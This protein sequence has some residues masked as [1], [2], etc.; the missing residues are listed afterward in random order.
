MARI[1]YGQVPECAPP[2]MKK[3]YRI[4]YQAS[5]MDYKIKKWIP[6][7][8]LN[9][10]KKRALS[11]GSKGYVGFKESTGKWSIIRIYRVV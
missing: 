2:D 8:F 7:E 3:K 6:G 11:K 9:L 1:D 10:N 4:D 5:P